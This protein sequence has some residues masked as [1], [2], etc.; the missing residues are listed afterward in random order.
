MMSIGNGIGGTLGS[1]VDTLVAAIKIVALPAAEAGVVPII[2]ALFNSQH[3]V[4]TTVTDHQH[5]V[6][7]VKNTI[8]KSDFC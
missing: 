6:L 2:M 4:I 1:G 8:G 3:P 7:R 5:S